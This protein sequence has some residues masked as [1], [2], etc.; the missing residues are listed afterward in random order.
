MKSILLTF[1]SVISLAGMASA[2]GDPGSWFPDFDSLQ[3]VQVGRRYIEL[4]A[5]QL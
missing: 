5:P 1:V 3:R 4:Y 2:D